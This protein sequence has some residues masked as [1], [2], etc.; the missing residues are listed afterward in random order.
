[1]VN[2][3]KRLKRASAE[4]DFLH[5][6][7]NGYAEEKIFKKQLSLSPLHAKKIKLLKNKFSC[8]CYF[9]QFLLNGFKQNSMN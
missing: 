5:D 3:Q 7:N 1:M 9:H 4:N 6:E 8:C 2:V